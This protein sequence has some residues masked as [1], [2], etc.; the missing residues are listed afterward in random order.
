ML[1]AP[2]FLKP[3]D[4]G[5]F[6]VHR[7]YLRAID[8][9]IHFVDCF[10][11]LIDVCDFSEFRNLRRLWLNEN[12]LRF[13]SFLPHNFRLSELYISDNSLVTIAHSI[14]HL[15]GLQTLSLNNNQ[16]ARLDETVSELQNMQGLR[17]LSTSNQKFFISLSIFLSFYQSICYVH[18]TVESM[19]QWHC[20][21][22]YL[23]N[24][25][26]MSVKNHCINIFHLFLIIW[27]LFFH[28][29]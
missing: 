8:H 5:G 1:F 4:R 26:I 22:D 20:L 16:L 29:H 14:R 27:N 11:D 9:F 19:E 17:N 23:L 6:G 10:R 28:D 24:A 12:R 15:T 7:N 25:H 2:R 3:L 13:I 18:P 21:L